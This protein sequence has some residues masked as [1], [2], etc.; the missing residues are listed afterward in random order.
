MSDR[1]DQMAENKSVPRKIWETIISLFPQRV[2]D[3]VKIWGASVLIGLIF[4][5]ALGFGGALGLV[6]TCTMPAWLASGTCKAEVRRERA[7][8]IK[9]KIIEDPEDWLT[10]YVA[11]SEKS[12]AEQLGKGAIKD[13]VTNPVM[14]QEL[15]AINEFDWVL[16]ASLNF[17]ITGRAFRQTNVG[18]TKLIEPLQAIQDNDHSIRFKVPKCEKGDVLIAI[19]RI[20]S[21]EGEIPP[22]NFLT[23]FQSNNR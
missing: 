11:W 3:L 19:P 14:S 1:P 12:G 20:T 9:V 8:N 17:S 23:T 22:G 21:Q 4:G 13:Y 18:S 16:D 2:Q 5:L 7:P 15:S 10:P 6:N